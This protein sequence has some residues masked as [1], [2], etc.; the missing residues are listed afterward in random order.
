MSEFSLILRSMPLRC[1][2]E[3]EG[4]E[5][6]VQIEEF[7]FRLRVSPLEPGVYRMETSGRSQIVRVAHVKARSFVY[8]DG[9]IL[10]YT[11]SAKSDS[12]SAD[13]AATRDDLAAP[14]PGT[15][16]RVLVR[17]GDKIERG[18]PLVIVEA[19]KMEHVIRAPWAA[20]VRA[21]RA[22][23]GAQVDADA[24]L[25]EIAARPDAHPR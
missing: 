7:T 5:F 19:M 12:G 6:V 22:R 9:C 14:M 16:T 3:R 10:E 24:V 23:P 15:V 8:I 4:D 2:V 18:Q 11:T 13:R 20:T 21:V 25:V 17:E 1:S